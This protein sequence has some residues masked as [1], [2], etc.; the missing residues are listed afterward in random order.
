MSIVNQDVWLSMSTEWIAGGV[1]ADD[2]WGN[3]YGEFFVFS[4]NSVT[5]W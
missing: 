2:E 1:G 3:A 5:L 4:V